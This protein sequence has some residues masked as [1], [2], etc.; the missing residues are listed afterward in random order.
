MS[1]RWSGNMYDHKLD[2][3]SGPPPMHR[4]EYFATA[5]KDASYYRGSVVSANDKGE[6]IAGC[7]AG[8]PGNRPM[9]MFALVGTEDLDVYTD[10]FNWGDAVP[11]ALPATGGYELATTEYLVVDGSGDLI[12]YKVNDLLTADSTGK[13]KLASA[14]AGNA[15]TPIVGIVSIANAGG[16]VNAIGKA[17]QSNYGKPLL[18]F[19]TVF[20]PCSGS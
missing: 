6:L 19:W 20:F 14:D 11:S 4:L 10:K 3:V 18:S 16:R 5:H 12:E 13:L 9:P 2:T 15:T 8:T 17:T 1:Q 7:G